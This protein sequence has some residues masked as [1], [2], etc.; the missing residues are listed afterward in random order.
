MLAS[1][2]ARL[3]LER[4]AMETEIR[5]RKDYGYAYW[6]MVGIKLDGLSDAGL[7]RKLG[8]KTS[9]GRVGYIGGINIQLV[10]FASRPGMFQPNS[11]AGRY[12]QE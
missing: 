3:V 2:Q 1:R 4:R 7:R 12:K 8:N 11:H 10:N 5:V 9:R 6:A